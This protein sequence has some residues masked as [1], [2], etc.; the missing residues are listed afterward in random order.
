MVVE[1]PIIGS[2]EQ[3]IALIAA[4]NSKGEVLLP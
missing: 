3:V 4:F 2:M 1:T